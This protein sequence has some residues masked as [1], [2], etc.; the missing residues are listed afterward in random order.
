MVEHAWGEGPLDGLVNNAAGNFIARRREPEPARGRRGARHRA[1]MAPPTRR[2][3]CGRRWI[4]ARRAGGGAVDRHDYAWTGSGY[5]LPSAMARPCAGDDA[6]PRVEWGRHGVRLK[7]HRARP[8]PTKG[9]WERLAPRPD[10]KDEFERRNALGPRRSP[11]RN[12]PTWRR[13]DVGAL[14]LITGDCITIDG[15]E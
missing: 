1:C 4:A 13:S 3:A 8:F 7:R 12:S 11:T 5:V 15:G 10:I 6:Q 2:L 9:A 14:G